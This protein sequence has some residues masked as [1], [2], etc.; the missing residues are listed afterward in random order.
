MGKLSELLNK[1]VDAAK[2]AKDNGTLDVVAQAVEDAAQK[3]KAKIKD[4]GL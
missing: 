4:L 3:A 2:E 1:V